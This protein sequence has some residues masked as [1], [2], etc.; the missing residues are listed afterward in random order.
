LFFYDGSFIEHMRRFPFSRK[1]R[2]A[3][4]FILPLI[5]FV[6]S[7]F[8]APPQVWPDTGFGLLAWRNFSAGGTW[9]TILEPSSADI[10]IDTESAVTWWAPGQYVPLGMLTSAGL[11][12]G[13]AML[14]ITLLS[15]WSLALGLTRLARALGAPEESLPWVAAAAAGSWHT[16]FAF[17]TFIGGEVVLIALFPWLLLGAWRLRERPMLEILLLPV[18]LLVGSFAKHSFAIYAVGLLAF[19]W[20]EAL[21][22]GPR[23]LRVWLNATW[24]LATVG[25]L[26]VVARH[27]LLP[28]GPNPA[29]FGQVKR[30]FAES[31]GFAAHGPWLAAT[32]GGRF[33]TR[34]FMYAGLALETGWIKFAAVL[35]LFA[36]LALAL[37]VSLALNARPLARLAGMVASIA[38]LIM[39]LLYVSGGFISLD[40]RHFRPA[41]VLLLAALAVTAVSARCWQR[42]LA[43]GLLVLVVA[44]GFG[45]ALQRRSIGPRVYPIGE[46]T[47]IAEMPPAVQAEIRRIDAIGAGQNSIL[48]LPSSEFAIIAHI[49]R[50][51]VTD[52]FD[53]SPNYTLARP[54]H[55]RVPTLTLALPGFMDRQGKGAAV[56]AGFLDYPATAWTHY[57][58]ED[59]DFWQ[60][61]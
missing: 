35:A 12:L 25:V 5:V 10:A 42:Y 18:I 58:I 49:S 4:A 16:L 60:A 55:G 59:W 33:F 19:L 6:H 54:H 56:R 9:N 52:A 47:A 53:R 23:S 51:L 13:A 39:G 30:T 22:T 61:R 38:A 43:R 57:S 45:S 32:G 29:D 1:W 41:G 17:D 46:R 34:L 24:P 31:F 21:R 48:Y 36:P 40:D 3:P 7:W 27:L 15:A 37:Y 28:S 8:Y 20:L 50:L 11:S 26:Y 44:F 14:L 2:F